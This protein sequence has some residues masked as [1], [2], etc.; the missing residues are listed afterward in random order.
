MFRCMR[1]DYEFE[2]PK[3]KEVHISNIFMSEQTVNLLICPKC[4]FDDIEELMVC[5][6]CHE[7][8]LENELIDT[9]G[10][11]NGSVG[12]CCEQCM[13]DCDIKDI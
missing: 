6:I 3:R 9:E 4:E 11:L 5:N 10:M 2:E 7:Y 12:Y 8:F 1:C 13:E